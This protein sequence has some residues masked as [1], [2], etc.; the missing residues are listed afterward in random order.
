M[1]LFVKKKQ[2]KKQKSILGQTL[3]KCS[4]KEKDKDDKS[5]THLRI[6]GMRRR[7]QNKLQ[8]NARADTTTAV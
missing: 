4:M 7:D 2:T 1:L 6:E 8:T 5:I 3:D